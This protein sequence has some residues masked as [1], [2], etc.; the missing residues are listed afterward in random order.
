MS[1]R[2]LD[3]VDASASPLPDARQF[4]GS[5][6]YPGRV[7]IAGRD[8]AG[9][10]FVVYCLSGRSEAS[11]RRDFRTGDTELEVVDRAGAGDDPL[12]HYRAAFADD[13]RMLLGNGDHVDQLRAAAVTGARLPALLEE[14]EPEPDPPIFTPRIGVLAMFG[15]GRLTSLH[16]FGVT[17]ADT[18]DGLSVLRH[19]AVDAG[20]RAG[21][22][23][24]V[25]TYRG[26][27]S[28]VVTDG[29]PALVAVRREWRALVG[30]LAGA[31]DPAVR[32]GVVGAAIGEGVFTGW[33]QA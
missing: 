11:R 29:V 15:E 19:L 16:G 9:E 20:P 10:P 22:A 2:I 17:G 3:T 5:A 14:V 1:A 4:V 33:A 24:A 32:V 26:S 13:D 30:E 8:G 12:R 21:T 27:I 31:I 7:I 6:G 25:K 28:Q 23:V 18:G